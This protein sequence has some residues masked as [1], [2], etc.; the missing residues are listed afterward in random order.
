M[1]FSVMYV[2]Q[3]LQLSQ[4]EDVISTYDNRGG[5]EGGVGGGVGFGGVGLGLV[6]WGLVGDLLLMLNMYLMLQGD[7]KR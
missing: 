3:G 1:F 7:Q 6:G 2:I 5:V 4:T